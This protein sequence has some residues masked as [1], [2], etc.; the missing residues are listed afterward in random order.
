MTRRFTVYTESDKKVLEVS[1]QPGPLVSVSA[2]PPRP[3]QAPATHPFL[4]A[5]AYDPFTDGA[6]RNILLKSSSFD[7]F[8]EKLR[9]AGYRVVVAKD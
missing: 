9:D 4:S 1:D 2:P 6:L 5:S 8:L 3:G 7:D